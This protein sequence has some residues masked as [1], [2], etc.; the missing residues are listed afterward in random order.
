MNQENKE[1]SIVFS[2]EDAEM[3]EAIKLAQNEFYLFMN[4]LILES[5]RIVPAMEECLI[6]YAFQSD[7]KDVEME[8]MFLTDISFDG[9]KIVGYLANEPQHISTFKEGDLYPS[10]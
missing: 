2:N 10:N 6:K 3:Q 4:E 7:S 5:K 1:P 9:E 8:H